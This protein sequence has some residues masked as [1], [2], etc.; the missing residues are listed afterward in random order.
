MLID[1]SINISRQLISSSE[2]VN[3]SLFVLPYEVVSDE[4]LDL[5]INESLAEWS[6]QTL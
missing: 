6:S 1:V 5:L 4:E 2:V 3:D